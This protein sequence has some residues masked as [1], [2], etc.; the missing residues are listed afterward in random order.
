MFPDFAINPGVAQSGSL[1]LLCMSDE[2]W[3]INMWLEAG[4]TDLSYL[5]IICRGRGKQENIRLKYKMPI[6]INLAKGILNLI[7]IS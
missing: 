6:K 1:A 4:G 3:A 5:R 2:T 7:E